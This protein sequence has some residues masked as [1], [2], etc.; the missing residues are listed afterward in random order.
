LLFGGG[1]AFVLAS[2]FALGG[3][4]AGGRPIAMVALTSVTPLLLGWGL[5]ELAMGG[6]SLMGRRAPLAIAASVLVVPVLLVPLAIA[7]AVWPEPG[8]EETSAGL[9]VGCAVFTVVQGIVPLAV[10][11]A[12]RRGAHPVLP[13]GWGAVLGATAGLTASAMAFLR[14]PH[15]AFAHGLLAHVAPVL[16][17]ALA[18]AS[19]GARVLAVRAASRA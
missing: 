18:G 15:A 10:L 8:A 2:F 1:A 13:W 5:V 16:V 12:A 6:R 19:I 11:L 4:V 7:C 3:V 9:H 14:C 17:L